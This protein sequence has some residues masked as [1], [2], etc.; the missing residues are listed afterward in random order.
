MDIE[1]NHTIEVYDNE[2][3]QHYTRPCTDEEI[4]LYVQYPNGIQSIEVAEPDAD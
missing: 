2:T 1:N 3:G 4:E